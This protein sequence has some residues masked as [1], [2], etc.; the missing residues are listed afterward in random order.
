MA[1]KAN[2][3]S[4]DSKKESKETAGLTVP[5]ASAPEETSQTA[6]DHLLNQLRQLI[7][8]ARNRAVRAVDEI[9]V[10]TNWSVGRYIVEFE[11]G[12]AVRAAYGTRL[13]PLL[14]EKLKADYG[15]GYDA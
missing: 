15:Q 3:K 2:S 6:F 4:A 5:A 14:A 11:Q 7:G 8:D 1:K 10:Q 13:L 12:G 9:Q